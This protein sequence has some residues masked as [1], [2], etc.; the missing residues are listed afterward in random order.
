MHSC[1]LLAYVAV[2]IDVLIFIL[3]LLIMTYFVFVILISW[4][5]L[6]L[7]KKIICVRISFKIL[8]L[9]FCDVALVWSHIIYTHWISD[10]ADNL[11]CY[12]FLRNIYNNKTSKIY[13]KSSYISV[14][15][16]VAFISNILYICNFN[17]QFVLQ[18]NQNLV[19]LGT[20]QIH[21]LELVFRRLTHRYNFIL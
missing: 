7:V 18:W 16:S 17:C 20:G 11:R 15:W 4:I 1:A 2:T 12:L 8:N 6:A 19:I 10:I 5:R 21:V 9:V 3:Q 13:L 14:Y